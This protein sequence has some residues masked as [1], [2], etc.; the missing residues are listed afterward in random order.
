MQH[1]SLSI[2]VYPD[3]SHWIR[4]FCRH[5]R[6]KSTDY[7]DFP[8]FQRISFF[9]F[10]VKI[11]LTWPHALI[12][13]TNILTTNDFFSFVHCHHYRELNKLIRYLMLFL[14]FLHT[15]IFLFVYLIWWRRPRAYNLNPL[16]GGING[17]RN[18]IRHLPVQCVLFSVHQYAHKEESITLLFAMSQFVDGKKPAHMSFCVKLGITRSNRWKKK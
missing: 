11:N 6:E 9:F 14:S 8:N 16:R 2:Y 17:H 4:S 1:V 13:T 7:C 10:N 3:S 5:T 18:F 15:Y 12:W